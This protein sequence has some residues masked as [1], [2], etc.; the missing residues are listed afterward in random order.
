MNY[1][2]CPDWLRQFYLRMDFILFKDQSTTSRLW[3]GFVTFMFGFFFALAPTV[4]NELSE[5]Q[6][7]MKLAPD[8]VWALGYWINGAALMHGAYTNRYSKLK[9]MLEGTLGVV[10]WVGSAYAVTVTQ[11]SIGAHAAGAMVAFWIYVRYPT[12]W[13]GSR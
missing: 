3:F 9:L 11:G 4:H 7:M 10:I 2:K 6:L 8:W 13:E 12:H 1:P 5:Y